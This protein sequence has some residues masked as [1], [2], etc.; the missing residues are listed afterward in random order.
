MQDQHMTSGAQGKTLSRL[1][2][3][4]FMGLAFVGC[5]MMLGAGEQSLF[6][7]GQYAVGT[8]IAAR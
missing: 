8:Q 5:C 3:V 2:A 6:A 7:E 1:T 4:L